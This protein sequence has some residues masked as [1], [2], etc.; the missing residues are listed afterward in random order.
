MIIYDYATRSTL[1][2]RLASLSYDNSSLSAN[3]KAQRPDALSWRE[4]DMPQGND[5]RLE[6]RVSQLLKDAPPSYKH[7]SAPCV[8]SLRRALRREQEPFRLNS[9]SQYNY[10]SAKS[11]TV[12]QLQDKESCGSPIGSLYR[13][14]WSRETTI[15]TS[16]AIQEGIAPSRSF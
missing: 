6:G 2:F 7:C 5:K 3:P 11:T 9:N 10:Q 15:P 1:D 4:Q 8:K 14:R 12:E 16:P 13:Q